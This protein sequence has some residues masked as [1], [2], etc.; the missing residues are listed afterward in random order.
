MAAIGGHFFIIIA[1]VFYGTIPIFATLLSRYQVSTV[2][3]I[4]I[5]LALSISIFLVYVLVSQRR[6][7]RLQRGDYL[8]FFFFGLAGIALFFTFY[9]TAAVMASVTMAVLLLYTQPIFT[10]LLSRLLYKRQIQAAGYIGILL[11][12]FGVAVIFR[13][14][15]IKWADFGL[16]HIFGLM[17]G[18]LYSVYIIFM[19]R[20]TPKY[21]T[22]TV[23][24]WSFLFGLIWLLP[25]WFVM[26][27]IFKNPVIT[28]LDIS[29]PANAWLLLL[30]FTICTNIIAYLTF[31]HGMKTV[32]PHRAGVLVLSEPLVAIILGAALLGQLLLWTD[33]IGGILI[34]ASF[35]IVKRRRKKLV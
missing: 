1:G 23:T 12:L 15:D 32:E 18:L 29:L 20:K 2:E 33:L 27:L 31:N 16:G 13:V 5:R 28:G 9:V 10:L 26:H 21:N 35:L 7:L 19:S 17:T 34:L 6:S 3:Q 25:L 22:L 4:F 8:H 24:F 11:A 30:A 14:W